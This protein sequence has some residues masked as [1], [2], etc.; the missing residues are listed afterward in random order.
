MGEILWKAYPWEQQETVLFEYYVG[1]KGVAIRT[2]KMAFRCF[3]VSDT[4]K[5]RVR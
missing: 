3:R 5:P 1:P 2:P 4:R